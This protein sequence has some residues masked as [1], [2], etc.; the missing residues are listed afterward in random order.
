[1][2]QTLDIKVNEAWNHGLRSWNF[3]SV[4]YVIAPSASQGVRDLGEIGKALEGEF[5]FMKFPEFQTYVNLERIVQEFSTDPQRATKAIAAHEIGHRF[6]PYDAVTLL[7]LNNAIKKSLEGQQLPYDSKA[8]AKNITNLFT[9][10]CLNTRLVQRGDEDISWVYQSLSKEKK[11]SKLWNVYGRSMELLWKTDILPKKTKLTAEEK[12]GA[13]EL[14]ELFSKDYFDKDTWK[15]N[16][17]RYA[18]IISKFLENEKQDG[19]SGIDNTAGNNLPK[20]IDEKTAQELAKRL[21]QIGS[22]GLPQ[23]PQGMKEF[24]EI[25]AGYGKGDAKHASIQFYDMLSKSYDVMFATKPFGRPRTNPF[26]PI[27]WNPSMGA[28]RLD[29]DY[30]V[31]SGGRIIPGANTYAWNTRRR[32]AFGGLEEVVPNLDIYLDTSMSM[33]NPLQQISLPVLAGFV[34][35]K[36]AHRKGASIRVTNFSGK[37]QSVTQDST[38]DLNKVFETLVVHYNGGTVFPTD[39]LAGGTD[40][41]QVLIITDTFLGNEAETAKAITDLRSR[42]KA[43]KITVYGIHSGSHGDYL[44][45]AG[46]EVIQGTTTD[47]FRKVIGKAD[48]VYTK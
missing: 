40:P 18:Q 7:I 35:A 19:D 6:C 14:A 46:A 12:T 11:G 23:N 25:M 43:N 33:P 31:H 4:P 44:R 34:A 45:G 9:D 47:I 42:N 1:M 38:T 21:A 17:V 26:Q 20:N 15:D 10:T 24:Q 8:A 22:D 36:K 41:K 2:T 3:P 48:E 30:S 29:V 27:K 32:E 16:S 28:D 13:E 37:G 39:V 5:A